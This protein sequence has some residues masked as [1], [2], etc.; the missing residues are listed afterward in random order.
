MRKITVDEVVLN[1]EEQGTGEPLLL[2]HGFPLDHRMWQGQIDE[3]SEDFRVIAPDLRG[4]GESS[5]AADLVTMEQFADDLANLLDALEIREKIIYCGLSMGGYIAWPFWRRH[6]DRISKLILCD[7]RAAAD[8]AEAAAGRLETAE[9]VEQD[10]CAILSEAM[11]PKLFSDQTRRQRSRL[12]TFTEEMIRAS[13]PQTAAAALRG[14]AQRVDA[15]PWLPQI[16]MPT[17][18]VCGQEDALTGLAEMQA[19]A[20]AIPQASLA[21]IPACGHMAPLEDPVHVNK[22]IRNFLGVPKS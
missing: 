21:V 17:L 8:S 12:I 11:I 5:G 4:F 16:G 1:V 20:E 15:T 14:M 9:R 18:V 2:V 10:G 7:T 3:L 13:K 19:V 22:T 6:A